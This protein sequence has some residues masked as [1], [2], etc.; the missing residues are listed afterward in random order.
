[1]GR[2]KSAQHDK[3]G[4]DGGVEKVGEVSKNKAYLVLLFLKGEKK[5]DV[6]NNNLTGLTLISSKIS[7]HM[8]KQ[9]ICE[10]VEK[11]E[12]ITRNW[13]RYTKTSHAR[14]TSFPF[15]IGVPWC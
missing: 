9:K 12:A 13:N 7:E 2:R 4:K 1:M 14:L 6:T 8:I 15:M 11:E 10:H 5:I 3:A